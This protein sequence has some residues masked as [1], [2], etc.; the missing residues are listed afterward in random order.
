M[1]HF[2]EKDPYIPPADIEKIRAADPNGVFHLYPA[3]HGF[4]CDERG[5][6]DAAS[7]QLARERTLRVPGRAT[8]EANDQAQRSSACGRN[9]ASSAASGRAAD[10]GQTTEIRNPA[11]GEVLGTVPDMG[12]A[13]TRRAIEAAHAAM[14]A[15]SKKTAG[16]RAQHHAQVV[17]SHDGESS[18]T[19]RSS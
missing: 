5:S 17:R 2:G 12:A 1:Y 7:A 6:Y 10:S 3:D 11:N 16:E 14:P 19:S 8:G 13:E 9:A 4:N 18:T 15:W